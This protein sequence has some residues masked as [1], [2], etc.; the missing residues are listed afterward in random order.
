MSELN[1]SNTTDTTESLQAFS[2]I[3]T[4]PIEGEIEGGKGRDGWTFG[5]GRCR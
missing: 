3:L 2:E 5:F 4:T 1:P